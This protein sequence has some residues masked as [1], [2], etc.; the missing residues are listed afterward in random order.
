MRKRSGRR[1]SMTTK[2]LRCLAVV[3]FIADLTGCTGD[4]GLGPPQV[5]EKALMGTYSG[6]VSDGSLGS[7]ILSVDIYAFE[8]TGKMSGSILLSGV[9]DC[10]THAN[11]FDAEF[12][13]KGG[14][15]NVQGLDSTKAIVSFNFSEGHRNVII[16][17]GVS[18]F[19]NAQGA[20]CFVVKSGFLRREVD[21]HPRL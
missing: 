6:T 12:D 11:F 17:G 9:P 18:R 1:I 13:G 20:A 10:F 8:S 16:N 3:L 4:S 5:S 2:M 14:Q 21:R 19:E 7:G 15:I